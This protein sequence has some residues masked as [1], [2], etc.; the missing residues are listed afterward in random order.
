MT[1][2]ASANWA[3]VGHAA[4]CRGLRGDG[5]VEHAGRAIPAEGCEVADVGRDAVEDDEGV[6]C[7]DVG[8]DA[9]GGGD[10]DGCSRSSRVCCVGDWLAL[11]RGSKEEEV[12]EVDVVVDGKHFGCDVLDVDR[13][14]RDPAGHHRD[15]DVGGAAPAGH[16]R[17]RRSR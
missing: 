8:L 2:K 12:E 13:G 11:I 6:A 4:V 16:H 14:S 7:A 1:S 5:D 15:G 17:M 3:K 9:V 10:Q